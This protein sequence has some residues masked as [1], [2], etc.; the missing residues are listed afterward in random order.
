MKNGT[1]KPG[2][3]ARF[4]KRNWQS[5][6]VISRLTNWVLTGRLNA[7]NT[8]E[9]YEL[10]WPILLEVISRKWHNYLLDFMKPKWN[11]ER[12]DNQHPIFTGQSNGTINE[13]SNCYPVNSVSPNRS[14][15]DD[16]SYL[17]KFRIRFDN[18]V[19]CSNLDKCL[20]AAFL[21]QIG[22]TG[23]K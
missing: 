3:A 15:N 23:R 5:N 17:I 22:N 8:C 16:R 7:G 20:S 10:I 13:H 6:P 19:I 9:S 12:V 1:P 21:N 11:L 2:V 14:V 4:A 18:S